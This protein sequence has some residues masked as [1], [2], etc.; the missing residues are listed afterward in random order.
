[1]PSVSQLSASSCEDLETRLHSILGASGG[2]DR[3]SL[4]TRGHGWSSSGVTQKLLLPSSL[5]TRKGGVNHTKP[6]NPEKMKSLEKSG[7]PSLGGFL[8]ENALPAIQL[9]VFLFV[10]IT[11]KKSVA[12]GPKAEGKT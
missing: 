7:C 4:I 3:A 5:L 12:K 2:S 9:L 1:M 10:K 6:Q 8:K 11:L